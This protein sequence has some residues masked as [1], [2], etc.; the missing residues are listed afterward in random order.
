MPSIRFENLS[1]SLSRLPNVIQSIP[2]IVRNPAANPL[3]TAILLGIGLVL[4]LI[5]VLSV[6]IVLM[7]PSEEERRL[8]DEAQYGQ[9]AVAPLP[10]E[11]AAAD[12]AERTQRRMTSLTV[13]ALIILVAAG[14]WV[15]TGVT[16]SQ[17]QT[18]TSCHKT[19]S[20]TAATQQDP[21]ATVPCVDCHEGGG[22]FARISVNVVTRAEHL[23]LAQVNP[24]AAKA[25]GKP[26]A[27]DACLACHRKQIE[28][29]TYDSQLKVKISHT[30][31]IAAGAQC[32]DCHVMH[33]GVVDATTVGMAPCL[34]CHDGK[35]A[36]VEC[37]TCHVGDPSAAIRPS[38]PVDE[39]ARVLVPNPQ[40]TGCHIDMTRCNACHGISMPHS[41]DFKQYGHALPGALDL[42]DNNLRVCSKCHY[43][44][45]NNCVR[46]GCHTMAFPA[47]PSPAWKTL[48]KYTS[49][50]GSS[51]TCGCHQWNPYDHNGMN[52]CQ[53]CHPVKP[54][55]A[56]P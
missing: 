18:C 54:K 45:H 3:Q 15:A 16:T 23:V 35:Q 20:H 9:P 43:P 46:D 21:H 22:S 11:Q 50:S 40:C 29:T 19:T 37:S 24:S 28:Q 14:V 27:S 13:T 55:D 36:S 5:V 1:D 56:R 38:V 17:S 48:H 47:H 33:G 7:R 30:A 49:W 10:E 8:L 41:Q 31:P 51:L 2:D 44:G 53:I 12:R 34:R 32:T 26:I 25:F 42:W 4:A 39:L 52:F 6:F